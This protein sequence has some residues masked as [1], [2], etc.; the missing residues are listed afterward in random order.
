MKW[1]RVKKVL[2]ALKLSEIHIGAPVMLYVSVWCWTYSSS[3]PLDAES[4]CFSKYLLQLVFTK[5]IN[6]IWKYRKDKRAVV[7]FD[8][9]VTPD[10]SLCECQYHCYCQWS[11][12]PHIKQITGD[13][14]IYHRTRLIMYYQKALQIQRRKHFLLTQKVTISN[15]VATATFWVPEVCQRLGTMFNLF[16]TLYV[17]QIIW[18]FNSI[19]NFFSTF[20][21]RT[22]F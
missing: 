5:G 17:L 20:R 2:H 16:S 8:H 15:V 12:S 7:V 4:E 3:A 1:I 9:W 19:K 6:L 11:I 22:D 13:G 21:H 10:P 18:I 14:D